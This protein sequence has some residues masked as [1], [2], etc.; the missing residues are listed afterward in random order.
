MSTETVPAG[1]RTWPDLLTSL[2]SGTDM[3]QETAAWAMDQVL[4]GDL[5]PVQ[6]AGF[7]VALRAKGETVDE[8]SGMADGMLG[9]ATPIDL[10]HETVDIVGTGGDRANT[11]NVSTMAAIVASAAGARVVKHGNRAASSACGT[12]DCLEA[13]GVALSVPPD[14]QPEVLAS[15]GIVFLFAPLYH[16]SLRFAGP[17]RKELGIQTT[18]N[19]LGPL[20]NPARPVANAIGIADR[21]MAPLVS[22]VLARRGSRGLVFHGGDGLDE[23]TTTTDSSIWLFRDRQVVETTLDPADLGLARASRDDLVGADPAFN[24][25]VVR[26]LLDG[27]TGPVRDIVLL[28]AAGALLAFQGPDLEAPLADQLKGPLERAAEAVD[29]GVAREHLAGWIEATQRA[30]RTD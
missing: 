7:A 28:N 15:S 19:L 5:S 23:L 29:Q 30:T 22:Q 10:D 1:G 14:R 21:S 8:L 12:A 6:I 9:R 3:D 24:A 2:V 17:A 25:Q 18:F 13:L 11:V 4:S 16:A 27:R 20:S 26:D